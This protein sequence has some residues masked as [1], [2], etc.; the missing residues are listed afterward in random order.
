LIRGELWA[1][2]DSSTPEVDLL[3]GDAVDLSGA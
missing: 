2:L 3:L 1:L